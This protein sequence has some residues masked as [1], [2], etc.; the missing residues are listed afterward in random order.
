MVT[1]E[2]IKAL[3]AKG[4]TEL[5]LKGEIDSEVLAYLVEVLKPNSGVAL[6]KLKFCDS[7]SEGPWEFMS[8]TGC[9]MPRPGKIKITPKRNTRNSFS[10][11][12]TNNKINDEGAKAIAETLKTNTT[13]TELDF[14]V[15]LEH[16]FIR[17]LMPF[18]T[19]PTDNKIRIEGAEAIGEAL[20]ANTS[21]TIINLSVKDFKELQ[22]T[23][24]KHLREQN[25]RRR[26]KKDWRGIKNK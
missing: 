12:H 17:V 20:K 18:D 24:S 11:T 9:F 22:Q 3:I 1:V 4:E 5:V 13:L 21:L 2:G 8:N 16:R 19:L 15:S 26:C 23:L 7:K 6:K 25:W 14:S 10:A